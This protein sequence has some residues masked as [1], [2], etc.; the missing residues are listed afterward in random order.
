MYPDTIVYFR[1]LD[2]GSDESTG[3]QPR[4]ADGVTLKASL[5]LPSP[6]RIESR[7][8]GREMGGILS[9]APWVIKTAVDLGAKPDDKVTWGGRVLMIIGPSKPTS[10]Q[11]DGTPVSYSTEAVE[12]V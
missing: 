3:E 8:E 4:Y 1:R 6:T 7:L 5:Q 11:S 2:A 12:R 10:K 9:E